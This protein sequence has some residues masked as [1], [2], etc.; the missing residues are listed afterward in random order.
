M[1]GNRVAVRHRYTQARAG[2]G[3]MT[4][5]SCS[6]RLRNCNCLYSSSGINGSNAFAVAL[7]LS[8][9]RW[10]DTVGCGSDTNVAVAALGSYSHAIDYSIFPGFQ[11][12][13]RLMG[14]S[15]RLE[16]YRAPALLHRQCRQGPASTS[17]G[18]CWLGRRLRTNAV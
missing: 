16:L 1:G 5:T 4:R 14:W 18:F 10:N 2:T 12:S 11:Y 15:G 13:A 9:A 7:R 17:A 8:G 3:W 6:W